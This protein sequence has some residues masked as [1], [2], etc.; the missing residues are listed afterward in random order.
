MQEMS[1]GTNAVEGSVL[2]APSFKPPQTY[3]TVSPLYQWT[4]FSFLYLASLSPVNL[5]MMHLVS[6]QKIVNVLGLY[7]GGPVFVGLI[8]FVRSY[9]NREALWRRTRR[10]AMKRQF[11]VCSIALFVFVGCVAV[12]IA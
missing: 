2:N 6:N 10:E 7:L 11:Y 5:L 4:L 1:V 8:I 12:M 9:T 3:Y